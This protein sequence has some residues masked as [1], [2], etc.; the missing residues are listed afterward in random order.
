MSGPILRFA[1]LDTT[2]VKVLLCDADGNLFPSE[3]PA[4]VAS[5]KYAARRKYRS[6]I[7]STGRVNGG[8]T[9]ATTIPSTAA[10]ST[11]ACSNRRVTKMPSS[12]A[13]R[14]RKAA[15]RQ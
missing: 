13:V 14:S 7:S 15:K 11:F 12:S 10:R 5:T 1:P 4:F 6:H 8:T 3:E 9:D 2:A